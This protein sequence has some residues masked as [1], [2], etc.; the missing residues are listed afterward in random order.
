MQSKQKI[1]KIIRTY[2][3][4]LTLVSLYAVFFILSALY[5]VPNIREIPA[6]RKSLVDQETELRETSAYARYL[7]ELSHTG[8]QAEE[9]LVNYALPSEN[10]VIS[11]ITTYVGISKQ[12]QI[13]VEPIVYS[14][15]LLSSEKDPL[16]QELRDSA[17]A[18][19]AKSLSGLQTI[20]FT[21]Q[22]RAENADA[23][24]R[25]IRTI[26]QTRRIFDIQQIDWVQEDSGSILLTF[27]IHTYYYLPDL[28]TVNTSLVE[29][30]RMNDQA[31]LDKLRQM[32]MY[33]TLVFEPIQVGKRDLFAPV[34]GA[35]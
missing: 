29:K 33:D 13:T 5:I 26:H 23:A 14:P 1:K 9:E 34:V 17:F 32:V 4:L 7:E 20:P 28:K 24:E 3:G 35:L 6:L 10:D 30:G 16:P 25:F 31:L 15:G 8:L 19:K 2:G 11:F 12:S 22:A 27:V 21:M 18:Y